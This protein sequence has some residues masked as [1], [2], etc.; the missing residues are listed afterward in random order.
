MT[1][2]ELLLLL[3]LPRCMECSRG[4]AMRILSVRQSLLWTKRLSNG[5]AVEHDFLKLLFIELSFYRLT[6]HS[7]LCARTSVARLVGANRFRTVRASINVR[8]TLYERRMARYGNSNCVTYIITPEWFSG[9]IFLRIE[10]RANK[11]L[12][13]DAHLVGWQ[14][15]DGSMMRC[16]IR[17]HEM[18]QNVNVTPRVIEREISVYFRIFVLLNLSTMAAL[19]SSF[20]DVQKMYAVMY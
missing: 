19:M 9:W 10:S 7:Y 14:W 15:I 18:L 6:T 17:I 3:C 1:R 5:W 8:I 4:K 13:V 12:V 11:F 2:P 20:S 16:I